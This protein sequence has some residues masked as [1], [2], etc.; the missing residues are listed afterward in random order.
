MSTRRALAVLLAVLGL[1]LTAAPANAQ[2]T[3]PG[4]QV[5]GQPVDLG[6]TIPT[7]PAIGPG[8]YTST[9]PGSTAQGAPG[10]TAY[11]RVDLADGE[12]LHVAAT[13]GVPAD[14]DRGQSGLDLQLLTPSGD[15]CQGGASATADSDATAV[16]VTVAP[17]AASAAKQ[18]CGAAGEV[19]VSV[20]RTGSRGT[21]TDLPLE[22]LVRVQ[23][24]TV[25]QGLAA[26]NAGDPVGPVVGGTVADVTGGAGFGAAPVLA[27]GVYADQLVVGQTRYYAL[28]VDWGQRPA[29]LVQAGRALTGSQRLTVELR[30]PVLQAVPVQGSD[31]GTG[32]LTG[33]GAVAVA[34]GNQAQGDSRISPL[35]T[36]GTYFLVVTLHGDES[37]AP[38]PLGVQVDAVGTAVAAPAVRVSGPPLA[39]AVPAAGRPGWTWPVVGVLAVAGLGLVVLSRRRRER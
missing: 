38:V 9:L 35:Y 22:L 8:R 37:T 5:T 34:P 24:P 28:A 7:A 6:A 10:A 18:G 27:P 36:A 1:G 33:S 23:P 31:R 11:L 17:D 32:A 15:R 14:P 20:Q 29:Y 30:N 26:A 25:D 3:A 2:P 13:T 21:S 19:V 4:Y 16:T 39:H 12:R